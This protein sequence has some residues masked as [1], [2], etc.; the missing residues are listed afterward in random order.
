MSG[1]GDGPGSNAGRVVE[2]SGRLSDTLVEITTWLVGGSNGEAVLDLVSRACVDVLG[3]SASGVLMLDPRGGVQVVAASEEDARIL[4]VLEAQYADG[5]SADCIRTGAVVGSSD[6]SAMVELWPRFVQAAS[7]AEYQAVQVVPMRLDGRTVG[8]L[9]LFYV[10]RATL[11]DAQLGLGQVLADLA[12]LGLSQERDGSRSERVFEQILTAANDRLYL[13]HA[14][15][16]VAGA[17]D[18]DVDTARVLIRQ[19]AGSTH[20]SHRDVVRAIA[21]GRLAP[22]DL[23]GSC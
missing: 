15:G 8:G 17:L 7:A 2:V 9:N 10:S 18:V 23:E 22:A 19:H 16:L 3:A 1:V 6:V 12:V 20:R 5:P 4:A 14:I 11:D 13:G 21:D